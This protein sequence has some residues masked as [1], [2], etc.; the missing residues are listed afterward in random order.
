MINNVYIK[1]T[2]RIILLIVNGVLIYHFFDKNYSITLSLL[3]LLLILQF[4]LFVDHIKQLLVDIEKSIDGLLHNDYTITIS[5]K[6]RKNSLYHKI[7]LLIGKYRKET[8]QQTSEQ[9]IFTN[10]IESLTIG[11]LI[12]K[13][14]TKD[15]I[16]VFQINKTFTD[17]FRIPKFYN[18]DLLYEKITPLF[19][20]IDI[21]NWKQLKH[22]LS[23]TI[24][25]QTETFYLKTAVTKTYE[26]EY[27]V[28]S[29]ET[30]QQII[31]KK[32]KES[33]YKLMNVMSH[34]IINTITP[35]STLAGNLSSLLQEDPDKETLDELSQGL[36]IINKRSLH[37]TEFVNTYR[38]LAEL[39][40]PEKK[41]TN[42]ITLIKNT[43]IL[44]K[45]EFEERKVTVDLN[46]TEDYSVNIDKKQMEQVFINLIS[47]SLYAIVTTENPK[48]IIDVE[49]INNK[50]IISFIDNGCGISNEIKGN[51]FIPYFTT[52]KNG[53]GIGLTLTKSIVESHN[54]TIYLKQGEG[55]TNFVI[56]LDHQ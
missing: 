53:S 5:E 55:V 37:L 1:I 30:I 54:G 28:I 4:F 6:K 9:I 48:I 25:N 47:N 24:N 32:E 31:D 7:A 17:L 35:I 38:M 23:I 20:V 46:Y 10:I 52:R 40:T 41:I 27:L 45:K 22:L 49:Q 8:Q 39:P 12:L 36:R 44:F 34:E 18:W 42:I 2:V 33:W 16:E 15:T 56:S 26:F 14:D 19:D 3:C 29:I 50:I 51:I 43:L 21:N 11:I 13:K